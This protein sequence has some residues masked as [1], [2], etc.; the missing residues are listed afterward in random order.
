METT[1]TKDCCQPQENRLYRYTGTAT[2]IVLG[3]LALFLYA[4][5]SLNATREAVLDLAKESLAGNY[6]LLRMID[7]QQPLPNNLLIK[8]RELDVY[9][10]FSDQM[11][12]STPI[13]SQS[14]KLNQ[15]S[16][17]LIAYRIIE[18]STHSSQGI[19][20]AIE[21]YELQDDSL[22]FE[23]IH[24]RKILQLIAPLSQNRYLV[25]SSHDERLFDYLSSIDRHTKIATLII[26]IA[27]LLV[28]YISYLL[29]RLKNRERELEVS[30]Q[31]KTENV[32]KIAMTDAL[33]GVMSRRKFDLILEE[34]VH[35]AEHFSYPF[36]IIL[37]DIDNFKRIN[38]TYGHD[39]GDAV[40]KTI[41]HYVTQHIRDTDQFARWGG[42][43]FVIITPMIDLQQA[44]LLA[45]K[46]R[47][48]I[49]GL[50]H[51]TVGKITCSFGV[52][53][54]RKKEGIETLFKKA[55]EQLY[56][57]KHSGKNCVMPL[58]E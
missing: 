32:E 21:H 49:A 47:Q 30:Y 5:N 17:F 29:Y 52:S 41:A 39:Q 19:K 53:T 31:N 23:L 6:E 35:M 26:V 33:T 44:I 8:A 11:I 3:L 43:E 42:E 37:I 46:I 9:D 18:T 14:D 54:Y 4:Y 57:A 58:L 22:Y 24:A 50:N 25:L 7:R 15:D 45:D 36:C 1:T 48:G 20:Q 28:F 16:L 34:M 40:L 38:D 55:D 27:S 13:W 56:A 12:K 51:K 10:E 2:L